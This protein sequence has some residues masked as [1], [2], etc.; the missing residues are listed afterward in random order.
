MSDEI[1]YLYYVKNY[2]TIDQMIMWA[3]H[4]TK[5]IPRAM[6]DRELIVAWMTHKV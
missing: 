2:P 3:A 4:N 6:R 5:Y 1:A